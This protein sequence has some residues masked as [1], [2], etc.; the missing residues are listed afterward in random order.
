LIAKS[1]EMLIDIDVTGNYPKMIINNKWVPE[2]LDADKFITAFSKFYEDR[3]MAKRNGDKSKSD[4]YKIVLN[5]IYG[6]FGDVNSTFYSPQCLLHTTFTGQL[7]LLMLIEELEEVGLNVVSANTDGIVVSV[8]DIEYDLF[9]SVCGDWQKTTSLNLEET[10]YKSLYTENVNSYIAV[11]EDGSL[12][13]KG[14]YI[15]GDLGHNPTIKVCIDAVIDYL[16][17]GTSIED[18]IL[19]YETEP[20]NFLMVRKAKNGGYWKDKYLGKIVR[21]YWSTSGEAIYRKLEK[22]ELKK[23]GTPKKNPIV[24]ES[25]HAWPIMNLSDGLKDIHYEKY[26]EY[27]YKMLENM[28][29]RSN[30]ISLKAA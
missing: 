21:W 18:T 14:S 20:Q 26:I 1:G 2:H 23:D 6:K 16:L 11:K 9:K 4:I 19:N 25:E 24:A 10:R 29:V 17:K 15:E 22:P 30:Y 27:A 13:R 28:G 12:K 8:K 5:S 7:S 3:L